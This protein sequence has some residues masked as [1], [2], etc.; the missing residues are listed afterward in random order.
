MNERVIYLLLSPISKEFFIG[1]CRKD[2]LKDIFKDHYYGQR[3]QTRACFT[4]L[5]R[6]NLHPCLFIL[7][8]LTCTKVE[9]FNYVVIWTKI[10][11]ET[12][13]KSL[14]QGNVIK[15][16]E[17]LL[18]KNLHLYEERKKT[19]ISECTKCSGCIV[20]NYGRKKCSLYKG[21][22]NGR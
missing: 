9:A 3:Y 5:K 13:Y 19:D 16:I 4:E 14:N 7:E 15:Y 8:E 2:L 21:E 6:A 20:I 11:H 22:E 10:F 18:D 17:S 12:G 1:H